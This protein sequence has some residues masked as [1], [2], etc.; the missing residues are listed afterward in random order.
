MK[1][2]PARSPARAAVA[3]P[4]AA[5]LGAVEAICDAVEQGAGLPE[6]VR[7]AERALDAS[8]VLIDASSA[9]LAVAGCSP[10]DERSLMTR[11]RGVSSEELR[12]GGNV[13]GELRVRARSGPPSPVL[14]RLTCALVAG[15]LDRLRAPER[16]SEEASAD[17]LRAVLSR[18]VADRGDLIAR[19]KELGVDIEHGASV[20]VVRAHPHSPADDGW[21][22]RMLAAAERAGRSA[23]PGTLA[24][25]P[26]HDDRHTAA[27]AT[28]EGHATVTQH[29]VVLL[30]PGADEGAARRVGDAVLR[31]LETGLSGFSFAIGR[32]RVALDPADLHR[33]GSEALLAANVAEGDGSQAVLAFEETGAYRLLLRTMTDDPGVLHGFYAETLEPLVAYDEQYETPLVRTLEA[34]LESDG[35]V[36]NTAQRL[37]THRH[38]IRYRLE[39]VRELTGLDMGSSDG[40]EK[41]SLGLKAMRVLGLHAPR[42]PALEQ[43]A[44]GGRVPLEA[45]DRA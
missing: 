33:A 13:V 11:G 2:N 20:V 10:A 1:S 21:R 9:V 38:T 35:N 32:S 41:L 5:D 6:V 31:E 12:L 14:L 39:R 44:G 15:E 40:R 42:G 26:G 37:F 36:A 24:T 25:L 29:E 23:K 3:L 16:A 30:V 22:R 18:E 28:P 19:G 7:A 27:D 4:Q 17:F 8:L 34:F 45:K 43:G